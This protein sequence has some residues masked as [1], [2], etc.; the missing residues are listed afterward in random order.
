MTDSVSHFQVLTE[1]V[2][3]NLADKSFFGV[4]GFMKP[5][6][7]VYKQLRSIALLRSVSTLIGVMQPFEKHKEELTTSYET[8]MEVSFIFELC[9]VVEMFC[10]EQMTL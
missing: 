2:L 9:E 5:Y 7:A 8:I 10:P 6:Q 1:S 3:F 4:T